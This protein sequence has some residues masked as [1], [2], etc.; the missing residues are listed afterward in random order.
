MDERAVRDRS[1]VILEAY[2]ELSGNSEEL[3]VR[4]FLLIREAAKAE[5]GSA[6]EPAQTQ[7]RE[8]AAAK[9]KT[10]AKKKEVPKAAAPV[11][12]K[13]TPPEKTAH[14]EPE[15]VKK[16]DFEILAGLKDPWN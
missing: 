4:D 8:D 3:S 7:P 12:E 9:R 14:K 15:P 10:P 16:S 11:P 2:R 13:T 5:T 1:A 6:P